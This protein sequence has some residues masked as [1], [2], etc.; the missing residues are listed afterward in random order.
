[1]DVQQVLVLLA[2]GLAAGVMSGMFG[3]GGGVVI[4][5]ALIVLLSYTQK[6]ANA[7]SLIALLLPVGILGARE[8]YKNGLLSARISLMLALGLFVGSWLGAIMAQGLDPLTLK[9]AYGVFLLYVCWR[10]TE[11]IRW[12]RNW[13]YA[14][15]HPDDTDGMPPT[16]PRPVRDQWYVIVPLGF[17][18]G[19]LSGL[20]GIGGGVIIVTALI[21]LVGFDQKK[22]NGTSLGAMLLPVS[23][24]A[25]WEYYQAGELRQPEAGAF[26]ALGLLF[27]ALLGARLTLRLPVSTMKR[28]YSLF[29]LILSIRFLFFN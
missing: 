28:L 9:R 26:V 8:Y 21:V 4:V 16:T 24:L 15:T 20:F 10:F 5:P 19:V 29:L 2:V 23:L 13:R 17:V 1:M 11:P 25:V 7:I 3:I 18:A 14:A 22:A 27:G 6:Q 12:Y